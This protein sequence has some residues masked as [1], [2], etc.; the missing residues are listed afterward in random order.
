[1][2]NEQGNQLVPIS[3]V[4]GNMHTLCLTLNGEF[5]AWG[6]NTLVLGL[7]DE[8]NRPKPTKVKFPVE[9]R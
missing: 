3:F 1:V 4:L 7:G 8:K 5:Y 9:E 6:D 2:I